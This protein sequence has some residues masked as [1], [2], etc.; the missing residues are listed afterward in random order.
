VNIDREVYATDYDGQFAEILAA[1]PG[2]ADAFVFADLLE[3]L[4][5]RLS[6]CDREILSLTLEGLSPQEIGLRLTERLTSRSVNR[7]LSGPIAEAV[8]SLIDQG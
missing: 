2:E 4:L 1:A 5:N 8:T 6:P 7:R 3:T